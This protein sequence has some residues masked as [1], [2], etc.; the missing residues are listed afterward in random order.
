[1][2]PC[3]SVVRPDRWHLHLSALYDVLDHTNHTWCMCGGIW[4]CLDHV[5]WCLVVSGAC[6]VVSGACLVMLMDIDWYDLTWCIWADIFSNAFYWCA[7]AVDAVDSLMLLMCWCCWCADAADA[8]MLLMHWCCWS[9]DAAV[10]DNM[11]IVVRAHLKGIGWSS[12][13]RTVVQCLA[14]P[15]LNIGVFQMKKIACDS[16]LEL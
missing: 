5:W 4:W 15:L 1:M 11:Q 13:F 6:L 7:D 16:S 9:N 2:F 8:L 12:E 10:V 14:H 3:C